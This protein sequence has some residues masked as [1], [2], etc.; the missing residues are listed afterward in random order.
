MHSS[1]PRLIWML[2]DEESQKQHKDDETVNFLINN[3]SPKWRWIVVDIYR[4]TKR[5]GKYISTTF[6]D[7]EVNNCFSIY[8]TRWITS[9][10]KSNFTRLRVTWCETGSHLYLANHLR[11]SPSA[12][13]KSTIHLCKEYGDIFWLVIVWLWWDVIPLFFFFLQLTHPLQT[14][15]SKLGI[16]CLLPLLCRFYFFCKPDQNC[17]VFLF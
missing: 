15:I 3:Y 13:A 14:R 17:A 1:P 10:P 7:T 9:G 11:A 2:I 6:T 12:C 5:Q 8:H 4:A 16:S